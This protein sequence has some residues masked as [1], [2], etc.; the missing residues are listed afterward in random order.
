[1]SVEDIGA[2]PFG[3][4]PVVNQMEQGHILSTLYA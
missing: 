2:C 1:L 3:W 4:K